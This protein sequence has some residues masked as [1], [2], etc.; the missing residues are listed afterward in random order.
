MGVAADN[1][2]ASA[3]AGALQVRM[4]LAKGARVTKLVLNGRV[5]TGRVRPSTGGATARIPVGGP[6]RYGRNVLRARFSSAGR[7]GFASAR[8]TLVRPATGLV[9]I[10]APAAGARVPAGPL[11]ITVRS[12]AGTSVRAWLNGRD[13]SPGW[14]RR[15]PRASR[16]PCSRP[17]PACASGPT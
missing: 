1:G 7:V 15:A 2:L 8:F 10:S 16:V 3:S 11:T 17:T 6:L 12:S 5:V 9:R 14:R 4:R 13:V